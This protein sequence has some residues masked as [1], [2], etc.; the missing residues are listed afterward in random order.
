M[1]EDRFAVNVVAQESGHDINFHGDLPY[2]ERVQ[3]AGKKGIE[4]RFW[5]D[6]SCP[7]PLSLNLQVDKYG[8]LGKVVIRYRM[9]VLVF[10]FLAVILTLRAQ[11]REWN[12]GGPFMPFG[13]VLGQLIKTTF[14]KFSLLLAAFALF[15]SMWARTAYVFEDPTSR[16][17]SMFSAPVPY[18]STGHAAE[19]IIR[20]PGGSRTD[21]G[22]NELTMSAY[23]QMIHARVAR[24][25]SWFSAF[26]LSDALLGT[27]DPFFWFLAP[28]FFQLSIGIVILIWIALN[29][30]VKTIAGVLSCVSRRGGRYVLGRTIGGMLT[31][32]S[33]GVRRRVITTIIL[34]IMV[35]TFVPY[36]FAFVVA[37]LVHIVACVR[38]LLLAQAT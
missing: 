35:A 26:R 19:E 2:Y 1:Y 7:V 4:L 36:Q 20:G 31:K 34:F 14:W 37:V 15:Q 38:S 22:V 12:R 5:M 28:V 29:G 32:R 18:N 25:Q 6:P 3:L 21:S 10:T 17:P 8:G 13:V 9:V 33:R 24:N 23:D 27:N 16:T 11:F 30:L